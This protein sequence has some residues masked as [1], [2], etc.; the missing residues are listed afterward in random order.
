MEQQ[1]EDWFKSRLGSI[2]G[3]GINIVASTGSGYKTYLYKKA[4][5]IISGVHEES[6]KSHYMDRGNEFESVARDKYAAQR[7]IEPRLVGLVRLS[8]YKHYSPDFLIDEDNGF[9]EIKTRIPS[10]FVKMFDTGNMPTA[11]RRQ[12]QW[13]FKVTEREYCDYINYCPELENSDSVSSMIVKRIYPDEKEI[14]EL[15]RAC[16]KFIGE[17]RALIKRLEGGI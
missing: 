16:D 4:A 2:G 17:M 11:D 8:E 12:I 10:E 5:E 6:F 15:N 14:R 9:G 13:G 7:I 3:S 1:S